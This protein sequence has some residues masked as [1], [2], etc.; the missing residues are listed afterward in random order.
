[1]K[2]NLNNLYEFTLKSLD[3]DK[4]A[5][6]CLS[7]QDIDCWRKYLSGEVD[8][9]R[10]QLV[11][12]LLGPTP[13][14]EKSQFM[15]AAQQQL[16]FISDQLSNF[17]FRQKRK[18]RNHK[19]ANL[20]RSNYL[21]SISCIEELLAFTELYFPDYFNLRLK[22]SNFSLQA[23]LPELRNE[24]NRLSSVLGDWDISSRLFEC[25][26][27]GLGHLLNGRPS[28]S[29]TQYIRMICKRLGEAPVADEA[30]LTV[31]LLEMDF[32]QPEFYLLQV[33]QLDR[34]LFGIHGLAEQR[35]L[36]WHRKTDI[37]KIKHD[38]R[39]R[40]HP[41]QPPITTELQQYFTEREVALEALLELRR[42]AA[43][44]R[45]PAEQA[46]RILMDM[47]VPQLA[48]FFRIQMEIG[49]M[50]KEQISEVFNF[51]AQHF[52]TEK[53]Q[54]ISSANM[55]KLSTTIE[56]NTVLKVHDMLTSMIKWLDDQ[57]AV[58][59]YSR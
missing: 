35:E 59:N 20:I 31:F 46:F 40:L 56:F 12:F 6:D 18:W 48:L 37:Q 41:G 21:L 39:F 14:K 8:D 33:Y 54:F 26:T 16:V 50:V 15:T 51:V 45:V 38:S 34:S 23:V 28:R 1:M 24:L 36:L 10:Y 22:L 57:F 13:V 29:D 52:Y 27:R 7:G 4:L 19:H 43:K 30:A 2:T 25:V 53:A 11:A 58:S 3:P 9:L 49:L 47:T 55:L 32:N 17:L 44:D 42:A 5:T